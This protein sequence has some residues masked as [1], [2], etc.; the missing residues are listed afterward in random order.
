[1]E[2]VPGQLGLYRETWGG[3]CQFLETNDLK[4]IMKMIR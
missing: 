1:M 3:G 2:K 4:V